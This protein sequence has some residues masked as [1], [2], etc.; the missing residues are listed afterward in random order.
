MALIWLEI[1]SEY[2]QPYLISK[3]LFLF[4]NILDAFFLYPL[5]FL[6]NCVSSEGKGQLLYNHLLPDYIPSKISFNNEYF[7]FIH[8]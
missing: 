5:Q 4:Q 1:F 8:K 2:W 7:I 6:Y 3:D